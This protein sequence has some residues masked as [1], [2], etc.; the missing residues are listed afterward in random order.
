MIS[1]PEKPVTV[2]APTQVTN[3]TSLP[4]VQNIVLEDPDPFGAAPFTLPPAAVQ[5][6]SNKKAG[7]KA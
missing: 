7:G 5:K 2:A 6:I 3:Q 1:P 4:P